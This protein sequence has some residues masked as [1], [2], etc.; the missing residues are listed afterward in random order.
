MDYGPC[1]L[2]GAETPEQHG[3]VLIGC[4][5]PN[6]NDGRSQIATVEICEKCLSELREGRSLPCPNEEE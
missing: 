4:C 1:H 2:C 3:N 5:R 6:D